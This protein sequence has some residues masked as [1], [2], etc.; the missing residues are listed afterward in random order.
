MCSPW[1]RYI[2]ETFCIHKTKIAPVYR[3]TVSSEQSLLINALVPVLPLF[4]S[5]RVAAIS[6]LQ[7]EGRR[8]RVE[9]TRREARGENIG[10]L[11]FYVSLC[12]HS[13][14]ASEP[15]KSRLI[16][17]TKPT[18]ASRRDATRV[19]VRPTFL[20]NSRVGGGGRRT[21]KSRA[22][23]WEERKEERHAGSERFLSRALPFFRNEFFFNCG[24][25]HFLDSI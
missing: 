18:R 16:D 13:R 17:A 2:L 24:T 4:F 3:N 8:I 10:L 9:E 22:A 23:R 5:R 6:K 7:R 11:L 19:V 1:K 21:R 20:H 25:I 15:S 12:S 14:A